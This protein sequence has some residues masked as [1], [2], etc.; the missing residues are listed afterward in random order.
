MSIIIRAED[1][2]I[3]IYK[4]LNEQGRNTFFFRIKFGKDFVIVLI[5]YF[6]NHNLKI[7]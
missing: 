3:L 5:L 7:H 1:I 6:M 2:N 4:Y